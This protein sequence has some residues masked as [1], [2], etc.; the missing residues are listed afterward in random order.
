M[1]RSGNV[2]IISMVTLYFKFG[3]DGDR[4]ATRER[5]RERE[6]E[7]DGVKGGD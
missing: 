5:E 7:R 6:R 3:C 4:K 2:P 1:I